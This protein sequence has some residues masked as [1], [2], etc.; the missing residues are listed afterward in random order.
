MSSD[1]SKPSVARMATRNPV[2]LPCVM[3]FTSLSSYTH[4]LKGSDLENPARQ[5]SSA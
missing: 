1:C 3:A 5:M 2:S 4:T